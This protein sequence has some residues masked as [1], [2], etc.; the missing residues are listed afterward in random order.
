MTIRRRVILLPTFKRGP[1]GFLP[2]VSA[3]MSPPCIRSD[4]GLGTASRR[5]AGYEAA[6]AFPIDVR[7]LGM[8]TARAAAAD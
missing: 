8:R 6:P 2:R 3:G 1:S 7:G 5:A 4:S